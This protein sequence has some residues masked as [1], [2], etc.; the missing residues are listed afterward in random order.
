MTTE[1]ETTC[2]QYLPEDPTYRV[3]LD[4]VRFS[5]DLKDY[6]EPVGSAIQRVI[7]SFYR[8]RLAH[9]SVFSNLRFYL[10]AQ[11]GCYSR[12]G[13]VA[14]YKKVWKALKKPIR[15]LS[16]ALRQSQ[17]LE[18]VNTDGVRFAGVLELPLEANLL[19]LEHQMMGYGCFYFFAS[20]DF[21]QPASVVR[22][23]NAAA[24]KVNLD[25]DEI[26]SQICFEGGILLRGSGG[27]YGESEVFLELVGQDLKTTELDSD[28]V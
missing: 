15:S 8:Y 28:K 7:D 6:N 17:E 27:F 18:I 23:A 21:L 16:I 19:D 12:A 10:F 1:T 2:G 22:I 26:I 13:R 3:P 24:R 4:T 9:P 5:T 25:W 20:N 14:R 11:T